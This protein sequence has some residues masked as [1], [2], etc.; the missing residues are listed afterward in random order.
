MSAAIA[1]AGFTI[2][3]SAGAPPASR[4]RAARMAASRGGRRTL[5]PARRRREVGR[6]DRAVAGRPRRAPARRPARAPAPPRRGAAS[7]RGGAAGAGAGPGPGRATGAAW[8]GGRGAAGGR[9]RGA[10][11]AAC[12]GAG[13]GARG[14]AR[15]RGGRP[16]RGG[17]CAL[18][19]AGRGRAAR[20]G[21]DRGG[22]GAAVTLRAAGAGRRDGR[23][24]R[25]AGRGRAARTAGGAA[26]GS[27]AA[28]RLRLV[29]RGE[30]TPRARPSSRRRTDRTSPRTSESSASR[31]SAIA[32][33]PLVARVVAPQR[34]GDLA[35]AA[36]AHL[37]AAAGA[38]A[39]LVH[40]REVRRV[41]HGDR[42]VGGVRRHREDVVADGE[43]AR[44]ELRAPARAR[45]ARARRASATSN[46][47]FTESARTMSASVASFRS[48]SAWPRRTPHWR[49]WPS[50]AL[51]WVS[52]MMPA[53]RS[54]SP[55]R[56]FG[57]HRRRHPTPAA[58]GGVEGRAL[59]SRVG[60][61]R[62]G[63]RWRAARAPPARAMLHHLHDPAVGHALVGLEEHERSPGSR[64]WASPKAPLQRR[65]VEHLARPP[66]RG[67]R[68][69]SRR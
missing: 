49:W 33:T 16:R 63:S 6:E 68:R 47:N 30:R 36:D 57:C 29:R 12:A 23:S 44:E 59:T 3:G 7:A 26:A 24:G 20:R 66:R 9:G 40:D 48:T 67:R 52:S 22:A 1:W 39:D 13:A 4:S 15:R 14:G 8:A 51:S 46:P 50:A 27:G 31:S 17:G 38:E 65:L 55:R 32:S 34:L 19:A 5:R 21:G 58:R 10:R 45:R 62:R 37:H 56:F 61:A 54:I 42:H 60:G 41:A 69:G 25:V 11:G 18:E 43:L 28:G 53:S 35:I 2:S 64:P